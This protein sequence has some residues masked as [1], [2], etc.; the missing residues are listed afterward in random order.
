M[1]TYSVNTY[2]RQ[3]NMTSKRGKIHRFRSFPNNVLLGH[4]RSTRSTLFHVGTGETLYRLV[5][6][7]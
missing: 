5:K 4:R 1:C 7:P 6:S 2:H 3:S